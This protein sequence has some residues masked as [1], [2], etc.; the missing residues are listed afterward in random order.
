MNLLL[1]PLHLLHIALGFLGWLLA[2]FPVHLLTIGE[3]GFYM[4][5]TGIL[6]WSLFTLRVI[7]GQK[8]IIYTEPYQIP[9]GVVAVNYREPED[10]VRQSIESVLAGVVKPEVY[11][12]VFNGKLVGYEHSLAEEYKQAGVHFRFLERGDKRYSQTDGIRYIAQLNQ[13]QNLGVEIIALMDGDTLWEETTARELLKPFADPRIDA[14]AAAQV[15]DNP[16]DSLWTMITALLT[17]WGHEIGQ[18]WQ[19]AVQS[20]SCLRGRTNAFRLITLMQPGFLD[21]FADWYFMDWKYVNYLGRKFN[22]R[23]ISG[24]DG[25]L[26][27]LVLKYNWL[28]RQKLGGSFVQMSSKIHTLAEPS[29]EKFLKMRVRCMT[30]TY[31]RYIDAI[32]R[33]WFWAQNWR[34]KIEFLVSVVIPLGFITCTA[35]FT[36]SIGRTFYYLGIGKFSSALAVGLIPTCCYFAWYN[37]GRFIRAPKW[38]LFNNKRLKRWP[39]L[40]LAFL[41]I[42]S[43]ARWWAL[44][45]LLWPQQGWGTRNGNTMAVSRTEK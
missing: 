24:D 5:G 12:I 22:Y 11:V 23:R 33:S 29:F 20:S 28:N 17:H 38:V 2:F 37:L 40:V 45:S 13:E 10:N 30:N 21:E 3:W 32:F 6:F 36:M 8:Y 41:F 18:K 39:G 14:V 27:F 35:I 9:F 16:D 31:S 19:S 43:F 25:T 34:F 1:V 15:I 4:G 42:L 44:F 26:T 7:I